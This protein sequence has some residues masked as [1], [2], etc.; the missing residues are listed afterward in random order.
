MTHTTAFIK[1]FYTESIWSEKVCQVLH[2]TLCTKNKE[3]ILKAARETCQLINKGKFN[4]IT[5]DFSTE[6]LKARKAWN[7]VFQ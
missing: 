6:I 1:S 5:T 7:K 4:G 3:R 2:K